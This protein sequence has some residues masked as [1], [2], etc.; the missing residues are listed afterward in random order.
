L[1]ANGATN[2][3]YAIGVYAIGLSM[4]LA[5]C[6]S[7]PGNEPAPDAFTVLQNIPPANLTK[8]ADLREKKNWQNPYLIVRPDNVGLLSGVTA[9]QEQILKPEE[10]LNALSRLPSAAWPYGRVAA[11]LVQESPAESK[12]AASNPGSAQQK[13]ALRRN[14]GAVAG[15][16]QRANIEIVWMPTPGH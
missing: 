13:I 9:N 14:R 6:S 11:I 12:P 4:V 8:Y 16:L 1:R 5:A 2:L 3:V 10:V 15:E 7:P